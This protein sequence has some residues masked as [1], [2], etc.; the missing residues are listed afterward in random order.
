MIRLTKPWR[1]HGEGDEVRLSA[2][3]EARLIGAGAAERT[4]PD[5]EPE[6]DPPEPAARAARPR[7]P[8]GHRRSRSEEATMRQI[9]I[10][11]ETAGRHTVPESTAR[12][13]FHRGWVPVDEDLAEAWR[14]ALSASAASGPPAPS[15]ND[16]PPGDQ[17]T[18]DQPS[19]GEPAA[20]DDHPSSEAPSTG[21]GK[22]AKPA[23]RKRTAKPRSATS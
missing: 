16:E 4:G 13:L 20:D 8:A 21:E 12:V 5:P 9:T 7:S 3:A 19:D 23:P 18:A 6:P 2:A 17:A 22:A 10:V 1:G 14:E 15:G 11:H